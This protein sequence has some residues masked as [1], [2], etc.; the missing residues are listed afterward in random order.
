MTEAQTNRADHS[1]REQ[2]RVEHALDS[3]LAA[4]FV[5][6][7]WDVETAIKYV[8]NVPIIYVVNP[9]AACSTFKTSLWLR[10]D[11]LTGARTFA[12]DPHTGASSPWLKSADDLAAASSRMAE[13]DWFTVVRN[14]YSRVVSAYLDKIKDRGVRDA[15]T[16][17]QFCNRYSL[18]ADADISFAAFLNLL[19]N[20]DPTQLDYHWRPQWMTTM[21]G[22][23]P[24]HHIGRFEHLAV[25]FAW[26]RE[27]GVPVASHFSFRSDA[28]SSA[29][30]LIAPA[31]RAAIEEIYSLDFDLFGYGRDPL[32]LRP[33]AS[34]L[35]HLA[36]D[37]Q[38]TLASFSAPSE[39][40]FATTA[41]SS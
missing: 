35:T 13:C 9:K 8:P 5:P 23:L 12:D 33:E 16:W 22:Q 1:R 38:A 32:H 11:V 10:H 41:C 28:D 40:P 14:P 36:G 24:L 15:Y 21:V 17:G 25:T 39:I 29:A 3:T 18:P 19:A 37:I 7:T 26:M 30:S 2:S 31:D 6:K 27:R 34:G 20:D 4:G